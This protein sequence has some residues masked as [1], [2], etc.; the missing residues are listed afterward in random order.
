[1]TTT[2]STA[3]PVGTPA[4]VPAPDVD[5]FSRDMLDPEYAAHFKLPWLVQY[6]DGA[7]DEYATEDEACAAQRAHRR[8]VGRDPLT[9][10]PK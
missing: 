8:A 9:G 1:M 3:V 6:E 7:I 10:E 2:P 5:V 4:P